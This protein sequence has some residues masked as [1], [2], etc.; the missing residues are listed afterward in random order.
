[1]ENKF[2]RTN[3]SKSFGNIKYLLIYSVKSE[4]AN[5]INWKQ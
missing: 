3:K 1:M 4:S 2:S 5:I